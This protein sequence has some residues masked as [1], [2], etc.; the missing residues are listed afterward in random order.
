MCTH[1]TQPCQPEG[2]LLMSST[3]DLPYY[4]CIPKRRG[5]S[6]RLKCTMVMVMGE[7]TSGKIPPLPPKV[8]KRKN[9]NALYLIETKN[10]FK[11]EI[12]LDSNWNKVNKRWLEVRVRARMR[13]EKYDQVGPVYFWANILYLLQVF[14]M[15]ESL[16][17]TTKSNW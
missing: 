3:D 12:G 15:W 2:V 13:Q 9:G 6:N 14:I 4:C 17:L 11:L 16:I 5:Q 7:H 8:A 1:N 10:G